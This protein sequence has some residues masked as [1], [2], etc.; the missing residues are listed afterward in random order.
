M[1]FPQNPTFNQ[2]YTE[3]GLFFQWDGTYWVNLREK[4]ETQRKNAYREEADPLYFSYQRGETTEQDWLNAVES[5]RTRYPYPE[6]P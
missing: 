3:S 4:V 5:I 1:S 6:A 2:H